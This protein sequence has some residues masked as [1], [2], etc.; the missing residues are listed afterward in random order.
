[1]ALLIWS[2]FAR[3]IIYK[4]YLLCL[5]T[6]P[7]STEKIQSTPPVAVWEPNSSRDIGVYSVM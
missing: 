4:F 7:P 3:I 2:Y 1:M 6:H 5:T